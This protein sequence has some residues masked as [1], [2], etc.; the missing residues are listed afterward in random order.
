MTAVGPIKAVV[1]DMDGVL[2]DAKE[3]HFEALNRALQLFGYSIDRYDHVFTYDGLPTRR[4]LEVLSRDSGLP[5]ALHPFIN[6]LKQSYTVE[7]AH[8]RCRPNFQHEYALSRLKADG[9][10]LAVASNSIRGTVEL[11]MEKAR[12]R[13]YL[14]VLMSNEDVKA[15]KPDPEI[16][17]KTFAALG[18]TAAQCLV[19]EDNEHGLQA[20]RASG[21]HVMEVETVEAVTYEN[22]M[23]HLQRLGAA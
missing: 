22:I 18:V 23:S 15:P 2:V 5:T 11:L 10:L 13:S 3:W 17:H 12:L 7:I 14:N 16:Y 19:L 8:A 1:F 4:K 9:Y 21:A 20:A 6:E